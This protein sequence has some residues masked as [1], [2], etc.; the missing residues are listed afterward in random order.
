MRSEAPRASRAAIAAAFER[1]CRDEIEAPKPGNVH[2]FADGHRMT[3]GDF[4]RSAAAASGPLTETGARVGARIAGAVGASLAA[5]GVN[6]NLGI[7]L[8]CAPLAAAAEM[9]GDLRQSLRR[10]LGTLDRAD[11]DLC[12]RAIVQ[13]SP[14]GLGRAARL[15]VYAPATDSLRAAMAEAADRDRIALQYVSVFADVFERGAPLFARRL[16]ATS[17]RR[18]ATLSVYLRFLAAFPDTHIVRKYGSTVAEQICTAASAIE[19]QVCS[20]SHLDAALPIVLPWDVKL[21][22]SGINPGTSADLTVASLFVHQLQSVLPPDANG[23]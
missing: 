8:L 18:L 4:L 1:A 12:F 6:T 3:A 7:I 11:A 21:K 13:A 16:A 9:G 20:A 14:A 23:G 22:E 2:L 5:A 19:T 10:V 17:D 15:D